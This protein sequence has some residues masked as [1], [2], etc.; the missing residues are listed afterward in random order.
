MTERLPRT[1]V[2][3][4]CTRSGMSVTMQ[5]LHAGGAPCAGT[6]PDFEPYPFGRTP[7]DEAKGLIVKLVDSHR[8]LP[9]P[10]D[11][12]VIRLSRGYQDQAR[13]HNKWGRAM[14]AGLPKIDEEKLVR[15]LI[16]DYEVIDQ[17]IAKQQRSFLLE[18]RDICRET[19]RTAE[20]LAEFIGRELDIDAMVA[21]VIPR[22]EAVHD[23]LLELELL[24]KQ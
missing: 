21:A 9:P 1:I 2:V 18:F 20:R 23:R 8:H 12:D 22:T 17:W 24:E 5:M 10:G 7:W 14:F 19:R 16:R 11:Y 15:M 6:F 3:A 13:S 4:G